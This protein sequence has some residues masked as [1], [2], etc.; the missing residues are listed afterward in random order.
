M[1][2]ARMSRCGE[3]SLVLASGG[4]FFD[5]GATAEATGIPLPRDMYG[6]M[7]RAGDLSELI[8][9][10]LP[11]AAPYDME[12]AAFEAVLPSPGKILCVGTNYREHLL[13]CGMPFPSAPVLFGKF[14]NAFAAHGQDIAIPSIVREADYE[15]ELVIVIGKR[16]KGAPRER[17][18]DFVLGYTCGNDLSARD[19]QFVSTQWLIGKTPDGFAPAGPWIVTAGDVNPDALD[20]S[21]RVNGEVRQSAN[22]SDM[23]FDCAEIISYASS[24]MTLEPGDLIFTGTPHGVAMGYPEGERPWLERGDIVEVSIEGIGVLRNKMV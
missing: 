2:L 10:A 22:T 11:N 14:S 17:A 16:C 19:L 6:A 13:E 9:A 15:C 7:L 12:G 3:V 8:A 21:T 24:I 18:L 4:G 20:I 5:L 23:I 1:K